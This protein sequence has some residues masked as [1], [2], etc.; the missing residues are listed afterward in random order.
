MKKHHHHQQQRQQQQQ[1]DERKGKKKC[2]AT[3]ETA[4]SVAMPTLLMRRE[5]SSGKGR[6]GKKEEINNKANKG[7]RKVAFYKNKFRD[8]FSFEM[9]PPIRLPTENC[10]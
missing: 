10:K 7:D 1:K 6:E 4:P 5:G 9:G 8:N 3:L 2:K